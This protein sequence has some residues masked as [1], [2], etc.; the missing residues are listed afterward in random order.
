MQLYLNPLL[1]EFQQA[2]GT[3]I[4]LSR[5]FQALLKKLDKSG[6]VGTVLI[7]LSKT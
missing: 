1:C 7:D 4:A 5:Y 3:H 6:Y 2:H